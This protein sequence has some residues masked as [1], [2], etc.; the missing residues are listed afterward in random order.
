MGC[1]T[2]KNLKN[3]DLSAIQSRNFGDK[4]LKCRVHHVYDTVI[5]VTRFNDKEPYYQYSVRLMGI[6]TPEKKFSVKDP[7]HDKHVAAGEHVRKLL[8][9]KLGDNIFEV[10]FEDSKKEKFGREMGTIFIGSVNV[11]EWLVNNCLAHRYNGKKKRH[12]S[13]KKSWTR[14]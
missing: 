11:N 3:L 2:S 7:L 9:K 12:H 5:V 4:R 6:D 8:E 10:K 14:F 1:N 13:L